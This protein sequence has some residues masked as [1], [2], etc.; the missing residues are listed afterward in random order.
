MRIPQ[1]KKTRKPTT[2]TL[3][4]L[5]TIITNKQIREHEF[6]EKKLALGPRVRR[7]TP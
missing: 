4:G 3:R 6:R 7:Q 2:K 1:T 5:M